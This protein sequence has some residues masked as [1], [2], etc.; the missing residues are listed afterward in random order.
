MDLPQG[1]F[2]AL[3]G[4][5]GCSKTT[6]LRLIARLELPVQV[7]CGFS[8]ARLPR[9]AI[10]VPP[11]RRDLGMVADMHLWP[12]MTVRGSIAFALQSRRMRD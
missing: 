3:L 9:P 6:L 1:S 5:S 11:E 12:N 7:G 8:Q 10:S 2:L 4:P